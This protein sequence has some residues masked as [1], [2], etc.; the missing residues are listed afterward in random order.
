MREVDTLAQYDICF[1]IT[2]EIAI[3]RCVYAIYINVSYI[4]YITTCG[5]FVRS[6]ESDIQHILLTICARFRDLKSLTF[7]F[8]DL[9]LVLNLLEA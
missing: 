7:L 6:P 9:E 8:L 4:L 2:I 3:D 1:L 5:D